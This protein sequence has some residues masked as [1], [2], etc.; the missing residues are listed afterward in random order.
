M[1]FVLRSSGFFQPYFTLLSGALSPKVRSMFPILFSGTLLER[2]WL[3][4]LFK[5][6]HSSF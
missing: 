5:G 3:P 4:W 2:T 1:P 6:L